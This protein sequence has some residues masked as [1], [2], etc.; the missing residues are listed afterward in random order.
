MTSAWTKE[1]DP[2]FEGSVADR[3]WQGLL[4]LGETDWPRVVAEYER[5]RDAAADA[6]MAARRAAEELLGST[7]Y[8]DAFESGSSQA[9][10]PEDGPARWAAGDASVA[11]TAR[12]RLPA[13][14]YRALV[15]PLATRLP[16]LKA[17]A[18]S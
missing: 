3:F 7:R 5:R 4:G 1:A 8:A 11:V 13:E 2:S 15:A 10:G 14:H 9:P 16:W 12:R 6:L 18:G 17:A